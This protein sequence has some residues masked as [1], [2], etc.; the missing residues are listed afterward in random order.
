MLYFLLDIAIIQYLHTNLSH[1]TCFFQHSQPLVFLAVHGTHWTCCNLFLF[2][3]YSFGFF[4]WFQWLKLTSDDVKEQIYKLAKKGLTPSQ[5]GSDFLLHFLS[6]HCN[7]HHLVY[8]VLEWNSLTFELFYIWSSLTFSYIC[9]AKKL[10]FTE[11]ILCCCKDPRDS[12]RQ[13]R[14]RPSVSHTP[15]LYQN[16][17]R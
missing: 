15:V 3:S 4:W 6:R 2:Q 12:L 7:L 5:I 8:V 11:W 13:Q 14:V 1:Y 10:I 17:E 9:S 16:E